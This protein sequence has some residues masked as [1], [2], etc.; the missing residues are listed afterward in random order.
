MQ[1][2]LPDWVPPDADTTKPS[3]ARM[4]DYYLGGA[5]NFAVDRELAQQVLEHYPDGALLAQANRAYLH[6]AVRFLV[7]QGIRQ[8][9]DVGSGIPT[10]GN[11]HETA[12]HL[13]PDSRVLYVDHDPVAV[14]HSQLILGDNPTTRAM[15]SDLRRPEEILD[16]A[17]RRQLIDLDQPVGLLLVAVLHFVPDEDHPDD[18]VARFRDA[19]A[20]GSYLAVAHATTEARAA[21]AGE[22]SKLYTRTSDR[23]MIWRSRERLADFFT[24]WTLLEPGLVWLPEWRPD[25]PDDVGPDPSFSSS[26]A[27]M[28]RKDR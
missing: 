1:E 3:V 19:L 4:Y 21:E 6:R 13:A 22:V 7:S 20:P 26:I 25:W 15:Q 2:S 18:L 17:E 9:I 24:G 10:V 28:G 8:F 14:A 16:S 5:H 11:V 23:G 12:Q 27:G